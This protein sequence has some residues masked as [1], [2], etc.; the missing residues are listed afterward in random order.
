MLLL[1]SEIKKRYD[2]FWNSASLDRCCLHLTTPPKEYEPCPKSLTQKWED[3]EYRTR[4]ESWIIE[5]MEFFA[6]GF[7]TVFN[8]FGPGCLAAM[9]GGTHEWNEDTVWFENGPII[10][11]W[12]NPPVP[13]L[14]TDS[15]L[16]RLADAFS[17][18]LFR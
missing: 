12:T 17:E 2:A 8:Y 9:I 10:T 1:S 16:Y 18:K 7:P 11:D 15:P 4:K 6:E 13:A 3:L 5:N 14:Y